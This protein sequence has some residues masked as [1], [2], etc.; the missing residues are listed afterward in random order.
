MQQCSACHFY[1]T[2]ERPLDVLDIVEPPGTKQID[3]Q[4]VSGISNAIALDE[5]VLSVF[6]RY[7]RDFTMIFLLGGA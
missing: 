3:D 5:E 1:T 6:V 4:M 7:T 2:L